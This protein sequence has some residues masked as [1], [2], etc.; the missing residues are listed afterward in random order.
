M[1]RRRAHPVRPPRA[2]DW[3]EVLDDLEA[4]LTSVRNTSPAKLVAPAPF[5]APS[6][7]GPL[8]AEL[9]PRAETLLT[10][11]EDTTALIE[12]SMHDI[13]RDVAVAGQLTSRGPKPAS[14]I[15]LSA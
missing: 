2:R 15:D 13:R 14:S 6:G 9:R 11:L 12:R 3:V 10:L 1:N 7:L 5:V 8:P 4:Q